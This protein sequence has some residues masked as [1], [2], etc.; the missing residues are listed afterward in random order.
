MI[1]GN[2]SDRESDRQVA[3]EKAQAWCENNGGHQMFETSAKED[4]GVQDAFDA[5]TSLAAE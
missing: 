2:K 5:I 1:L 3:K 4:I